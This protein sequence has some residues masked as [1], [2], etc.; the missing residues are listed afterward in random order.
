MQYKLFFICCFITSIAAAQQS[1]LYLNRNLTDFYAPALNEKGVYFHT[2]IKPYLI[3]ETEKIITYD[4]VFRLNKLPAEKFPGKI[5]NWIAYDNIVSVNVPD[6]HLTIDPLINFGYGYDIEGSNSVWNNTRGLAIRGDIGEKKQVSFTTTARENQSKFPD[7]LA[8]YVYFYDVAP[9]Q[10]KVRGFKEKKS[11][12]FDYANATGYVS[13]TPSQHFNFQ[14][15]HDKNFIGDGYRSMILSD[16]ANAYPFF[17]ITSSF[18]KFKY[19]NLYTQFGDAINSDSI[20]DVVG[21]TRKWGSFHYLSFDAWDW[22]QIGIFEG[23]LWPNNDSTVTRSFDVNYLNPIIFFRPIE[24]GLGSPDNAVLGANLKVKPFSDF[25]LYGQFMMDDLDVAAA[26]NGKGYYRNKFGIQAGAKYFLH[27]DDYKHNLMLQLE[28]DQAN[29]YTYA[30]KDPVQ[31]YAHYN[32]PLAHPLG[33]NF[34]EINAIV[35]GRFFYRWYAE[36]KIQHAIIGYNTSD[37]SVVGSNI[38]QSDFDIPN[39]PDSYGNEIGQG[40]LTTINSIDLRGG[41]LLN[42]KINLNIEGEI[43][44]RT[45]EN[46]NETLKTMLFMLSLKTDLFNA[47]YDF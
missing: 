18:W 6:F 21:I 31:N 47:Y 32:Q 20:S 22:V 8:E 14:L 19:M 28:L 43:F 27:T 37:S 11:N 30:A 15:G 17:K 4:S 23:V 5:W 24:F 34:R 10:G 39:F 16:N 29:P 36:A 26:R 33:A 45:F 7:Y 40:L 46:E 13:Y 1:T 12:K 9:G 42:P 2:A 3:S 25:I 35:N 38:F 41:F 44:L